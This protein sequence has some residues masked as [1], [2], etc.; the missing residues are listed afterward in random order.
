MTGE[1][2]I[3]AGLFKGKKIK[4]PNIDDLRPTPNRLRE[5]LF[6]ILQFDI[7]GADCLDAFAGT[8]AL[9]FEAYSRGAKSVTFIEKNIE[10]ARFLKKTIDD[11]SNPNLELI[12]QDCL[13]YLQ[14]CKKTFDIIFLDPPFKQNLWHRC[15]DMIQKRHLLN[16]NASIYLES[17]MAILDIGSSFKCQKHAKVGDVFYAIFRAE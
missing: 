8:G 14:S 9:G 12:H 10:A 7:Q 4:V 11:F 2:K 6:N 15:C 3:I 1:I 5:S 17:A 16:P 13:H